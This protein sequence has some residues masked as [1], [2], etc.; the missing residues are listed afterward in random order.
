MHV[1]EIQESIMHDP[2][3]GWDYA[4]I[5]L[6]LIPFFSAYGRKKTTKESFLKE[7]MIYQSTKKASA[8]I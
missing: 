8:K 5:D 1:Q 7:L 6:F 2:F 4:S 3:K